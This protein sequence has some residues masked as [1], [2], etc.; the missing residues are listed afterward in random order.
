MKKAKRVKL[1]CG[2]AGAVLLC[3]GIACAVFL[4]THLRDSVP[5]SLG[6]VKTKEF[7]SSGGVQDYTDYAKYTFDDAHPENSDDFTPLTG[8]RM[9]ELLRY[10]DHFEGLIETLREIDPQGELV[11]HYD[12]DRSLLSS[13][14]YLYLYIKPDYPEYGYYKLYYFDAET[15]TL[16]YFHNNV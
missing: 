10:L 8:E 5:A 2:I 7:Y 14:D 4:V 11:A 9:R 15:Q 6:K 13:D 3:A 12:F 1:V 16:F